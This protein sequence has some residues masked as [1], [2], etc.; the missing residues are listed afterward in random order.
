[1]IPSPGRS[2]TLKLSRDQVSEMLSRV[3]AALGKART[4]QPP[5]SDEGGWG[6]WQSLESSNL[7]A[8][9][10]SPSEALL[11]VRFTSGSTY[12]YLSVPLTVWDA[13]L[14]APSHGKYFNRVIKGNYTTHKLSG[15]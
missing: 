9:R 5:P 7:A 11:D 10:Y 4:T 8:V 2:T 14:R 6:E 1:M 3:R 13:L 15:G 12:R